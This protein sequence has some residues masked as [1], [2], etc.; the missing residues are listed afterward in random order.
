MYDVRREVECCHCKKL[1]IQGE[2]RYN[3]Y[4][5]S[6]N[7]FKYIETETKVILMCV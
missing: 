2:C 6:Q 4:P 7:A 3:R 5:Q 1:G